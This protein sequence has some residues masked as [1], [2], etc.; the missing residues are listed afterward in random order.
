MQHHIRWWITGYIE[1]PGVFVT[2]HQTS[3]STDSTVHVQPVTYRR[4]HVEQ[5]LVLLA[6]E[7]KS[8]GVVV[9]HLKVGTRA[10]GGW[11]S[12][13]VVEAAEKKA[14]HGN[15]DDKI[16]WS[17][18]STFQRHIWSEYMVSKVQWHWHRFLLRWQIECF[19]LTLA[20]RWLSIGSCSA[21]FTSTI[22]SL[23][24]SFPLRRIKPGSL[25]HFAIAQ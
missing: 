19:F 21:A 9:N 20:W 23:E 17:T 13:P 1:M 25:L 16:K 4:V 6:P 10:G 14:K 22:T 15:S 3:I 8:A 5:L 24:I 2:S 11:M 12:R 18:S 7:K